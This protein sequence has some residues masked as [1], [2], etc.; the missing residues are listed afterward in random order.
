MKKLGLIIIILLYCLPAYAQTEYDAGQDRYV[1]GLIAALRI[2]VTE[3]KT[4][5]VE[6][7]KSNTRLER[8][9]AVQETEL[10]ILMAF[11]GFLL[12]GLIVIGWQIIKTTKV[13]KKIKVGILVLFAIGLFSMGCATSSPIKSDNLNKPIEVCQSCMAWGCFAHWECQRIGCMFCELRRG[14]PYPFTCR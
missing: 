2:T 12:T 7:G 5:N 4:D 11:A 6:L 1:D 3:L 10:K 13:V 14:Y 9:N 8:E